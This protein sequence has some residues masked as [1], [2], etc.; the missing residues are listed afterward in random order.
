MR[1]YGIS[2]G[3]VNMGQDITLFVE[4]YAA[5]IRTEALRHCPSD[6][7]SMWGDDLFSVALARA[8][9][10][11]P[12]FGELEDIAPLVRM[13]ARQGAIDFL[14]HIDHISRG[15]R[16]LFFEGKM[17]DPLCRSISYDMESSEGMLLSEA[18][19]DPSV[20][21]SWQLLLRTEL[22]QILNSVVSCLN[23]QQ[24]Q[25]VA[26]YHFEELSYKEIGMIFRFSE[27]RVCQIHGKSMARLRREI[28]RK[29]ELGFCDL[30][31]T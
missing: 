4:K 11:L 6:M 12:S 16:K 1:G 8:A 18:I 20:L 29:F 26:L 23:D 2:S 24:R 5:L 22:S 19:A 9:K 13:C 28:S 25:I 7:Y 21:T 3:K 17:R 15:R 14:R 31:P 27:S 30:L 10:L